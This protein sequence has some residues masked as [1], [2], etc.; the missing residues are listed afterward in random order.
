MVDAFAPCPPSDPA[1][2]PPLD[3]L[4]D[5][6]ALRSPRRGLFAEPTAKQ[7]LLRLQRA[8]AVTATAAA[9]TTA[10]YGLVS[11]EGTASVGL[12]VRARVE[13]T[14]QAAARRSAGAQFHAASVALDR[15]RVANYEPRQRVP[16]RAGRG[17]NAAL[18]PAPTWQTDDTHSAEAVES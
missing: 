15:Q 1:R 17:G 2:E 3:A 6:F 5:G 11:P 12:A 10:V 9:T 16:L 18:V 8:G 14:A 13:V 7:P 4:L